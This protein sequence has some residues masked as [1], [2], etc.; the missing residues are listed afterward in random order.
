LNDEQPSDLSIVRKCEQR[1]ALEGS[2]CDYR[3]TV[4]QTQRTA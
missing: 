2:R 3:W 1:K 4:T